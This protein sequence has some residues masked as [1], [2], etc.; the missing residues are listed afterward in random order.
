M[1]IEFS[2]F[3]LKLLFFLIYPI[4]ITIQDYTYASYIK[5]DKDNL[6]FT[7]F[8]YFLSYIF[9]GILLLIFKFRTK[10]THFRRE[11]S[12]EL[13]IENVKN[14]HKITSMSQVDIE[15][16]LILKKKIIKSTLFLFLLSVIGIFTI[17]AG[18]Y[19]KKKEYSNAKHSVRTFFEIT[20]F[21]V[22]SYFILQQKLYKHHFISYGLITII[23]IIIFIISYTY[24]KKIL[25]SIIFYFLYELVFALYD[26]LIKKYMNVFYKSPYFTMFWLG[27]I[28]TIALLIYDVIAYFVNP[29]VS[30]IIIGLKDNI[31]NIGDFFLFVLDLIIE[32]AW[33]L[34][35]WLLIYYYTPCHYFISEFISEYFYYL[36]N[37]IKE[38]D[39]FYST[40]NGI[41]F[42]ICFLLIIIFSLV[43]NEVIILNFWRLDYN[44]N[45]RIYERQKYE[46]DI[47]LKNKD[48]LLKDIE[49]EESNE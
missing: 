10:R 29:D 16:K 14:N 23:L 18:Y 30:G 36:S 46:F 21:A 31:D 47:D 43:F 38:N 40:K 34:G 20:N 48:S 25:E 41:L 11:S 26:V 24:L 49:E 3:N 9:S 27:L 6:L 45:K 28:S 2:E 13:S 37:V 17:Y 5:H 39:E 44:T 1:F 4:F 35:I 7:T 32:Y 8:R 22:L 19:F 12:L 15:Q 33:N 42:S